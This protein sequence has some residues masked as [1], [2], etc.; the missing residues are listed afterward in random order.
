M[1]KPLEELLKEDLL[2]D[3]LDQCSPF[4]LAARWLHEASDLAL[5][6]NPNAMV[7]STLRKKQVRKTSNEA[8]VFANDS[9][10]E[11]IQVPDARVVLCKDINIEHGFVVFYTNYQSAKGAQLSQNPVAAAVFHW[12]KLGRQV[13]IAGEITKAPMFDS[14]QYFNTRH[15]LSKLGAWASEQSQAIP[16]RQALLDQLEQEKQRFAEAGDAIPRP[17]HW[18]GYRLWADRIE[19]WIAHPGRIHDRALWTRN[20]LDRVDKTG[21]AGAHEELHFGAWRGTRLQP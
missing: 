4:A 19:C 18:G 13:R 6:P 17:P 10:L 15:P 16:S 9:N 2:P 14:E 11:A 12:D 1:S 8:H 7:I 21:P 5:Q 20:L 3:D